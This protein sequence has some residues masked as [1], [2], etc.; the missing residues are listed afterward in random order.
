MPSVINLNFVNRSSDA[1]NSHIVIFQQQPGP[2]AHTLRFHN[3]SGTTQTFVCFQT[4]GSKP[5]GLA[6]AWFAMPVAT[7]VEVNFTWQPSYDLV[8]ME[9]G[10]LAEGVQFTASQVVPATLGTENKIELT[11]SEGA[12]A[13]NAQGPAQMTNQLQILCDGTIP[14]NTVSVGI[15]MAG[16]PIEVMQA[17]SNMNF[18]F[19]PL[20][21]YWVT[22]ADVTQ[23]EIMDLSRLTSSARV[24]FPPNVTAMTATIN[25]DQSWTIQQ[26]LVV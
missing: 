4:S 7:G 11:Y 2:P 1:G 13:F 24:V 3:N 10:Q 19:T 25:V 14:P 16:S 15:G 5:A 21:N 26:G 6:P 18:V 9:T 20:A 12:F 17:A 8:W 22:L 23:G